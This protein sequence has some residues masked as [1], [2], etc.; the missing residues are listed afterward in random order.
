MPKIIKQPVSSLSVAAL[1]VS[2]VGHVAGLLQWRL[3]HFWYEPYDVFR[4]IFVAIAL[5]SFALS[6][7]MFLIQ[8]L[9]IYR[10]LLVGRVVVSLGLFGMLDTTV[11]VGLSF[12]FP[13]L[14]EIAAYEDYPQNIIVGLIVLSAGMVGKIRVAPPAG[15]ALVIRDYTVCG[16]M[17]VIVLFLAC[18]QTRYRQVMIGL[19]RQVVRL[20]KAVTDISA[21]SQG[22]L[23]EANTVEERSTKQERDRITRELHDTI[24]YSLTNLIMMLEAA[25]ALAG[26][27][28][29]RLRRTLDSAIGQAQEG[30]RETRRSLHLLRRPEIRGPEGLPAIQRMVNTY[31]SATSTR[32]DVEYGNVPLSGGEEID[33]FLYHFVQEGLT[34]SFRH[35]KAT[36]IKIRFWREE[37]SILV[38]IRDNG[39]GATDITE[40]IGM[41]GMRERLGMLGGTLEVRNAVDGFEVKANVPI[42]S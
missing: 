4:S 15:D 40:G 23:R 26:V 29:D 27:D 8:D 25:K 6:V 16:A 36:M 32:V 2:T 1:S 3:L 12:M 21:A 7:A 42:R 31:E 33:R 22:Y 34:N 38:T 14:I 39:L 17:G 35:G 30:M 9:F 37:D 11:D 13:L 20:D 10:F 24:G 41:M 18:M 19:S 5:T 28:P